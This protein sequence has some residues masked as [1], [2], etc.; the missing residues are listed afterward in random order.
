MDTGENVTEDEGQGQRSVASAHLSHVGGRTYL[1][2][3]DAH[4]VDWRKVQLVS[5]LDTECRAPCIEVAH[6]IYPELVGGVH[7]GHHL[8]PKVSFTRLCCPVLCKALRA[9]KY[10][11]DQWPILLSSPT[12]FEP[13]LPP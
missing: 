11:F 8:M 9:G 1:G 10:A 4:A 5:G 7:V 6:R 12:G 2:L 3:P 13:V